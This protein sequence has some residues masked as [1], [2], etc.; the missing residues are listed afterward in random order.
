VECDWG[1]FLI[2]LRLLGTTATPPPLPTRTAHVGATRQPP[3][4]MPKG[5]TSSTD[6]AMRLTWRATAAAGE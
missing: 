3:R 2:S 4:A 6:A 5:A 1:S